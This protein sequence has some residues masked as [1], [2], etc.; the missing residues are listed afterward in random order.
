LIWVK[1]LIESAFVF[2]ATFRERMKMLAQKTDNAADQIFVFFPD[3]KKVSVKYIRGI[4]ATMKGEKVKR[5]IIVAQ[6][7][8]TPFSR[9]VLQA[10]EEDY[11]IEQFQEEELLVNI[12][13]HVLVPQH[14]VLTDREKAALL[15]KYKLKDTQLPRIQHSDPIA[16]YYGM[17]RGQVV[18]IIR[19]SETAGRYVT[20]RLV[21]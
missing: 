2:R 6:Q 13:K 21:I 17:T 4:E 20:Y 9:Q 19:S 3:E 8:L 1:K 10:M 18:K 14:R 12:T 5:A 7:G 16:R 15:E 11:L